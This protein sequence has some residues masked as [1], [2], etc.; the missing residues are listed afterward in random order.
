MTT[1]SSLPAQAGD[2]G[3]IR[4]IGRF[5]AIPRGPAALGLSVAALLLA[6]SPGHAQFPYRSA[7]LY[8]GM[9]YRFAEPVP[10]RRPQ[11]RRVHHRRSRHAKVERDASPEKP[12]ASSK[13]IQGPLTIVVSIGNQRVSIYDNDGLTARSVVS[14]GVRGHPT[15]T[16]VF[17]IIEKDRYHHSNLYSSA[18]MPFMQRITWDGV[19]MH[20]GV[21]PGHPASHG[22]IR[23]TYAFAKRL[24]GITKLGARVIVVRNDVQ[25]VEIVNP[26][27]FVPKPATAE[28]S[29][30]ERPRMVAN[31][32]STAT[33]SSSPGDSAKPGGETAGTAS[34]SIAPLPAADEPSGAAEKAIARKE[35]PQNVGP[36]SILVSRKDSRLYVR[37]NFAPLFDT[38]VTIAHPEQ[39]LGNHVYMATRLKEDGAM[40]WT[41]VTLP[42][43]TR[44]SDSRAHGRSKA[45][46]RRHEPAPSSPAQAQPASSPNEALDRIDIPQ[47]AQ[48]R[49]SELLTPGASLIISDNGTSGTRKGMEFIVR[50]R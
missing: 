31:T 23:L 36:I 49:I 5:A 43:E 40:R 19:A 25:P 35:Q 18:P 14:T 30:P 3:R 2:F 6:T 44:S 45:G 9:P 21:V 20:A 39:A 11:P 47:D 15:P 7:S 24:W 27:L 29:A 37:Q 22:C 16:G 33:D 1:E 42:G 48:A 17:S 32:G 4:I 13:K 46:R 34:P 50:T 26:R 10:A 8:Y 12:Q 41:V 38:G 28:T